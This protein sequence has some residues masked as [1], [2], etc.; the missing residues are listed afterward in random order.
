MRE[1]AN[2]LKT[3]PTSMLIQIKTEASANSGVGSSTRCAHLRDAVA[4]TVGTLSFHLVAHF[5]DPDV[6]F[7]TL[8]NP[9]AHGVPAL[10][11]QT[12]F[13]LRSREEWSRL[14][15][16]TPRRLKPGLHALKKPTMVEETHGWTF[17]YEIFGLRASRFR[18]ARASN[19]RNRSGECAPGHFAPFE[20]TAA[21]G[22]LGV[23]Q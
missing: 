2:P 10:A 1:K 4:E 23:C 8:P 17:G 13:R 20:M 15:E 12:R 9:T 3:P 6:I 5:V 21:S 7:H 16:A 11:G 22:I 18:T 14:Q 19:T